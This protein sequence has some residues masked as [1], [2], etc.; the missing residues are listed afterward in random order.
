MKTFISLV[1]AFLAGWF[2]AAK[3]KDKGWAAY[4]AQRVDLDEVDPATLLEEGLFG[5]SGRKAR[6]I[7]YQKEEIGFWNF[8]SRKEVR[9]LLR[10][11]K[12]EQKKNK[13]E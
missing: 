5:P 7:L 9:D 10:E 2:L 6:A 11:A 13:I 4:L 12:A 8:Q 1:T 3:A